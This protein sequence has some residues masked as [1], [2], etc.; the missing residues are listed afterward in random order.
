MTARERQLV[1]LLRLFVD[2]IIIRKSSYGD[3]VDFAPTNAGKI[4]IAWRGAKAA[5]AAAERPKDVKV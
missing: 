3:I 1:E 4:A 5:L 2:N